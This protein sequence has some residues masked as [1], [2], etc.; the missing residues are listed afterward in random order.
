MAVEGLW[1]QEDR[2][3]VAELVALLRSERGPQ[4]RATAAL[5][6]GKFATL[7]QENKLT[8]QDSELVYR[9][10]MDFLE[11]DIE[12]L[13]VRRRCLEAVA[14][15]NTEEVHD[16]IRWAYEDDDQD[17]RSSAVYSMGRTGESVWLP[18]LLRELES[19]DPAVRY[20]TRP[21]LRR[22]G[23]ARSRPATGRTAPGRRPRSANSRHNRSGQN[24]RPP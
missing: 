19:Y 22:T 5:A 3:L 15:Y 7:S 24:R 9:I 13:E 17:L 10:L 4:A 6:L 14:P 11:D 18:T 23:P 20:E 12:D 8:P 21:R 1:E 16:Y 2:W